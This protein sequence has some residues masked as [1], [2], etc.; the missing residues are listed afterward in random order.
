MVFSHQM[1]QRPIG[2]VATRFRPDFQ[3]ISSR[4]LDPEKPKLTDL[5]DVLEFGSS[6]PVILL[7]IEKLLAVSHEIDRFAPDILE[8]LLHHDVQLSAS[9]DGLATNCDRQSRSDLIT[10]VVC[11]TLREETQENATFEQTTLTQQGTPVGQG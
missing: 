2:V 4:Q 10:F 9:Q 6:P 8:A 3:I 7:W 5:M 1:V 11:V